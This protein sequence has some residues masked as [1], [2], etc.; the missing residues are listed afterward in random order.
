MDQEAL[1]VLN[2][3]FEEVNPELWFAKN[4]DFDQMI[5]QKFLG[6]YKKVERCETF[7]WRLHPRGRLA[8][9]LVLD[10][11]SRNIFRNTREAF[12]NDSLALVLAQAAVAT[13][14]DQK[15]KLNERAFVYMPYM[16][17][18]SEIIHEEAVRLFS[19]QGL[20]RSLEFEL[21]HKS[22]IDRFGR[23]PHR[24]E[25]LGRV[26]TRQE[27]DFLKTPGSSF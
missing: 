17:S 22:L 10:Q 25:I 5:R 24:N 16:H 26:S 23:Y 7:N 19:Q 8:E 9:I 18:E 20:E 14:D 2:F 13:K 1:S 12:Q 6:I 11:F 27:I 3:W 4:P 21:A 15:L